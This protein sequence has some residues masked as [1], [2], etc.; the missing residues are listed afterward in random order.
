MPKRESLGDLVV[1]LQDALDL[2]RFGPPTPAGVRFAALART[3]MPWRPFWPRLLLA[4]AR[5]CGANIA[6][7]DY[8]DVAAAGFRGRRRLVRIGRAFAAIIRARFA[9]GWVRGVGVWVI[10]DT[11]PR[12]RGP[13]ATVLRPQQFPSPAGTPCAPPEPVS[14]PPSIPRRPTTSRPGL[15]S[16][17]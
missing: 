6:G 7:A 5:C 8:L 1:Q 12:R 14:P 10:E 3:G 13:T 11:T 17:P 2:E 4:L 15:Y 9:R 16:R